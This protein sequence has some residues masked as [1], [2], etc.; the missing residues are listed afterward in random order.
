MSYFQYQGNACF[1]E[2]YGQGKPIVFLHGNTA[3]SNMFKALMPLYVE[4]FRC[5]L[6]D[7]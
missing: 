5:I 3:S 7:F 6:I 1:Y 4:N 2:E